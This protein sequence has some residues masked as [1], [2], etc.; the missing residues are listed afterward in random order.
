MAIQTNKPSIE[1]IEKVL[2]EFVKA[3]KKKFGN[4]LVSI[5]LFGSHARKTARKTSDVD[6]LVIVEDLPENFWERDR[7]AEEIS[8]KFFK[9]DDIYLEIVLST[10]KDIKN[11]AKHFNPIFLGIL[12]GYKIIYDKNDFFEKILKKDILPLVMRSAPLFVYGGKKWDLTK[13]AKK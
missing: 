5:V 3:C 8:W 2:S 10:K 6:L 13:I 1:C 7:I 12:T 4:K 9:E 11:A